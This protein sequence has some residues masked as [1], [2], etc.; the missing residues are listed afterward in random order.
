MKKS[1][2]ALQNDHD[3]NVFEGGMNS[4]PHLHQFPLKVSASIHTFSEF[5]FLELKEMAA[6]KLQ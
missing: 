1:L 4:H 2:C 3:Q 5:E 6:D